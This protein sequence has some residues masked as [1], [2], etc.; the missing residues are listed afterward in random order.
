MHIM[1]V[2]ESGDP[3]IQ[4]SPSRYYVLSGVVIHELRWVDYLNQIID[5]RRR[6]QRTFGLRMREEISSSEM[7]TK[8]GSLVRIPRNDRL[9]IIRAF[10][11]ELASLPDMNIIN[12][13]VDKQGKQHNY[14]VFAMAWKALLQRF[15]NTISNKN[16][17]GPSNPDERGMVFPD[18]TDNKKLTQLLRQMRRYNPVP[19]QKRFG[20][21]YR[22]LLIH[23]VIEDP[24]FRDSRH[25][26]FIQA[27][28]LAAFL[29]YQSLSP[30]AYMKKKGGHNYFS[31]LDPILCKVASQ[32]DTQGIVRL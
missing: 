15:E 11:L 25:S 9:T 22:N 10:T 1:Y 18:N 3:G 26:Y 14:D 8:P 7:M 27:A 21:G 4:G 5:F 24:N 32:S 28:D 16:F 12:V 6:M 19:Q 2:D 13:V 17:P 30:S 29:L 20:I 23:L 31:R